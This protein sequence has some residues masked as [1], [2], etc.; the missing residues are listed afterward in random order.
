[1]SAQLAYSQPLRAERGGL[2][3][4]ATAPKMSFYD[5]QN[6]FWDL[7]D[8]ASFSPAET[9]LYFYLLRL[10]N[11]ARWPEKIY[12]KRNTLAAEVN[13]DF[14]TLDKARARLEGRGLLTYVAGNKGQSAA[15]SLADC[16]QME[17]N[18]SLASEN[19]SQME[20]NIS[21]PKR[22]NQPDCSQMEGNISL[23]KPAA[24]KERA[25]F[26]EKTI[27]KEEEKTLSL[28]AGAAG[29]ELEKK[30]GAVGLPENS[31]AL[32]SH[33]EGGAANVAT[34]VPGIGA[35]PATPRPVLMRD[36]PLAEF[37]AFAQV[38]AQA[39]SC[40]PEAYAP[41]AQADLRHYHANLLA[42]SNS[43]N[44]KRH[45]WLDVICNSMRRDNGKG[46]LIRVSAIAGVAASSPVLQRL[47][48]AEAAFALNEY[49]A[50]G[51]RIN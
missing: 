27:G 4:T 8:E 36:S 29:G 30:L 18:I 31:N 1:M 17:G 32:A 2:A 10:F 38:F 39:A 33:T 49:D 26:E 6:K 44:E 11:A 20:G 12:R 21:S 34:S 16:S 14:K 7:H 13:L 40:Y 19:S 23:A 46:Q 15:W 48:T 45:G 3:P 47:A 5:L 37:A 25:R 41:F 28:A 50:H 9:H 24:Y 51:N 43:K 22:N 35:A 42:W